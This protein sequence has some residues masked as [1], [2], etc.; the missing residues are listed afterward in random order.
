MRNLVII[1]VAVV[2]CSCGFNEYKISNL[3][4]RNLN[5]EELPLEVKNFLSNRPK[6]KDSGMILFLELSDTTN[7]SLET[8]NTLIG[9]WV[10]YEKLIDKQKNIYYKITQE[11][12]YPYIIFRNKLYIPDKYDILCGGSVFEAIYTEYQLK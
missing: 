9:P 7:F 10:N 1:L 4:K 8:V 3:E 11:V 5:F 6:C 2:L 12:P